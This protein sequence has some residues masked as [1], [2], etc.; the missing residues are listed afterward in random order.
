MRTVAVDGSTGFRTAAEELPKAATVTDPFHVT[1]LAGN[2]LDVCRRRVQV[3]LH[4]S[5]GRKHHPLYQDRRTLHTGADL[6]TD[7]QQRRL[8]ALF[9]DDRDVERSRPPGVSTSGWSRPTAP[10]AGLRGR[11]PWP[12]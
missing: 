3:W 4:G 6:L 2:A 12:A 11:S 8:D 9:A 5:R 7:K 10:P 1:R